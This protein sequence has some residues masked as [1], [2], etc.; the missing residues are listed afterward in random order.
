MDSIVLFSLFGCFTF[1]S[2]I[3]D[4]ICHNVAKSI[5]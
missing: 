1:I 5:G 3:V 2:V 4:V